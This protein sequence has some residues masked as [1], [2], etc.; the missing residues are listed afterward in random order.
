VFLLTSCSV[1]IN[2]QPP[3]PEGESSA[4]EVLSPRQEACQQLGAG[5]GGNWDKSQFLLN[6]TNG[7]LCQASP[8]LEEMAE[9]GAE[10]I[11]IGEEI[12]KITSSDSITERA[13]HGYGQ[14]VLDFGKPLEALP[15]RQVTTTDVN[16]IE[17][18]V[19]LQDTYLVISAQCSVN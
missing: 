6:S 19:T 3:S 8:P 4:V 7:P 10:L 2:Q 11:P 9:V 5:K 17:E 12:I 16:F 1:V 13:I 18:M 15:S 14:A